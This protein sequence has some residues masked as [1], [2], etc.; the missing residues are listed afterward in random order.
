M[1]IQEQLAVDPQ[2]QTYT[3]YYGGS[4]DTN[5]MIELLRKYRKRLKVKA[6]AKEAASN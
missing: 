2:A 6:Q 4:E 3:T 5:Q 1:M